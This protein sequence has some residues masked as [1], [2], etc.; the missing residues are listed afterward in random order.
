[1]CMGVSKG[2][3]MGDFESLEV[4]VHVS[5]SIMAEVFRYVGLGV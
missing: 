2:L 5:I 1:M 3:H 4:S